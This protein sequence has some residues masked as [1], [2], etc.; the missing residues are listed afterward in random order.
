MLEAFW[1][2]VLMTCGIFSL[3]SR[4][5]LPFQLKGKAGFVGSLLAALLVHVVAQDILHKIANMQTGRSSVD[6]SASA[7][8]R[9]TRGLYRLPRVG[10]DR[11]GGQGIPVS[12]N[13]V[14]DDN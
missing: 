2:K 13:K 8:T 9:C 3:A 14:A 12:G 10:P 7:Y 4:L 5:D 11:S 6:R 1:Y